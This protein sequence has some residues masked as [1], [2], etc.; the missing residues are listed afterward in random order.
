MKKDEIFS[1]V[2]LLL[3]MLLMIVIGDY[4]YIPSVLLG[5]LYVFKFSFVDK[6]LSSLL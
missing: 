1:L 6:T 2:V 4:K 5:M 3:N